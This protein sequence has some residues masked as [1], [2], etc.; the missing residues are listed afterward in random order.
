[1]RGKLEG[2]GAAR[3]AKSTGWGGEGEAAL[4]R[5]QTLVGVASGPLALE[6]STGACELLGKL[7]A[8]HAALQPQHCVCGVYAVP[9][10]LR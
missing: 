2:R 1:M 5:A 6:S 7:L 4:T 3:M 10:A 9:S 8:E